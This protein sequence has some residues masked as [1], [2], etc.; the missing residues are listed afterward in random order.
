MSSFGFDHRDAGR[1]TLSRLVVVGDDDAHA[2]L[3]EEGHLSCRG[4][5]AVHGDHQLGVQGQQTLDGGLGQAV[6]FAEAVRHDCGDVSAKCAQ[7]A[8]R[9]GCGGDPVEVEVAEDDDALTGG[10]SRQ[11]SRRLPRACRG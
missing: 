8:G 6:A 3:G 1:N 5:A 7:P 2:L 4:D 11:R 9:D 10:E